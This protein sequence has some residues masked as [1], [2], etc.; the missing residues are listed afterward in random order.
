M[1]STDKDPLAALFTTTVHSPSLHQAPHS[2]AFPFSPT[3]PTMQAFSLD[4]LTEDEGENDNYFVQPQRSPEYQGA[5]I[6]SDESIPIPNSPPNQQ[7]ENNYTSTEFNFEE[8]E[9]DCES[10]FTYQNSDSEGWFFQ[11]QPVLESDSL[12]DNNYMNSPETSETTTPL[13]PL[14][15]LKHSPSVARETE[16]DSD[17][18]QQCYMDKKKKNKK[19][20]LYASLIV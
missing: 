13:S 4:V 15:S 5:D 19:Y 17:N 8:D 1:V 9:I 18:Q 6:L 11:R 16:K 20:T 12:A 10:V 3:A 7:E 2:P 14:S